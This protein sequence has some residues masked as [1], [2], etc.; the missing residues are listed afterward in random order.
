MV[1]WL[2]VKGFLGTGA[3]FEAD[4]NLVVRLVMAAAL[5]VGV[6]LAK[7]QRYRAH[8]ICQTTVLLLNLLMI[9]LVMWPS[10]RH[11]RPTILRAKREVRKCRFDSVSPCNTGG[12]CGRRYK[13]RHLHFRDSMI[14]ALRFKEDLCLKDCFNLCIC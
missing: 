4:I 7:Q 10:F 11:V 13:S 12:C 5:V 2:P 1:F 9:E 3:P 6:V 14:L 8:G